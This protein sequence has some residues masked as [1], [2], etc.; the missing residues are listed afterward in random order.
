MTNEQCDKTSNGNIVNGE[1]E[2]NK[3]EQKEESLQVPEGDSLEK[4]FA[5]QQ[6]TQNEPTDTSS[7]E[8]SF[9]S[10]RKSLL[11]CDPDSEDNLAPTDTEDHGN[12]T[13]LSDGEWSLAGKRGKKQK[14]R[15]IT[16]SSQVQHRSPASGSM[17]IKKCS[18]VDEE[19]CIKRGRGRPTKNAKT[20]PKQNERCP[21]NQLLN[22][23][24]IGCDNCPRWWHLPCVGLSGLTEEMVKS[25]IDWACPECFYSPHGKYAKLTKGNPSDQRQKECTTM[26][27][28]VKEELNVIQPVIK[29]S[30]QHAVQSALL[31]MNVAHCPKDV[32]ENAVKKYSEITQQSQQKVIEQVALKQSTTAVAEAVTQKI[33]SDKIVRGQKKLNVVV[34][35]A[36]ESK[37]QSSSERREDDYLFCQEELGMERDIVKRCYRAGR[38]DA[39]KPENCR[40][41]VIELNS[42]GDVDYWTNDGKGFRTEGGYWVNQDLCEAD[43][44]ANFL[45][46]QQR[47]ER[48][49][50]NQ[51]ILQDTDQMKTQRL[52][53]N[54]RD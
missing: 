31:N 41:L 6:Q 42:K 38:L 52:S 48:M 15:V 8:V 3:V 21:C 35:K 28:I 9:N 30:V 27:I 47:R 24:W 17:N 18:V 22:V 45:M 19:K 5:I 13:P 20:V 23:G 34:M 16:R 54:E 29:A 49:K 40:P 46:R 2:V 7:A 32:V 37:A 11:T 39:S 44:K 33:D 50:K 12:E 14:K 51:R 43:R 25:I 26:R 1:T 53:R 10:V 4:E 36:P